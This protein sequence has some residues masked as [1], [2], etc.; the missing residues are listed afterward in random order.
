MRPSDQEILDHAA[1]MLPAGRP[2]IKAEEPSGE[3]PRPSEQQRR[4]QVLKALLQQA[5]AI[6][7]AVPSYPPGTGYNVGRLVPHAVTT[8]FRKVLGRLIPVAGH[9]ENYHMAGVTPPP[10]KIPFKSPDKNPATPKSAGKGHIAIVI[11][12]A[13]VNKENRETILH[14][15]RQNVIDGIQALL[16]GRESVLP[17]LVRHIR[18]GWIG[19]NKAQAEHIRDH[20]Y[21]QWIARRENRE[22]KRGTAEH[23][24]WQARW[25]ETW[26]KAL[27]EVADVLVDGSVTNDNDAAHR[28]RL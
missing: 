14:Q 16:D 18:L 1:L 6:A 24:R 21:E 2:L 9:I 22:P 4:R 15:R 8:T 27:R 26:A 28:L 11:E 7:K 19:I 17:N 5:R 3:P 23:K 20:R 12:N 10:K 13:G 25:D